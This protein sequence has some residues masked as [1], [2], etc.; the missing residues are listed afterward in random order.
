M[1]IYRDENG[2]YY[3]E[4]DLQYYWE[5]TRNKQQLSAE[6][7]AEML[8]NEELVQLDVECWMRT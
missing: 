4:E 1:S 2:D 5:T 7:I 3:T 6:D 8:E